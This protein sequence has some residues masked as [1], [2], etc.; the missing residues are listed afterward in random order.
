MFT[1]LSVT[2]GL[3]ALLL[4]GAYALARTDA[5]THRGAFVAAV[6]LLTVGGVVAGT[7][8]LGSDVPR[9]DG[10]AA[11]VAG[12]Q[13]ATAVTD[14]LSPRTDGSLSPAQSRAGEASAT[15]GERATVVA[16]SGSE[17]LTYRTPAGRERTVRLAGVDAPGVDGADPNRFDGVVT[18]EYGRTCLA[19]YGRRALLSVRSGVVG[20]SVTVTPV[21][22]TTGVSAAV[23]TVDGRSVNRRLVERGLARATTDRYADAE[24]AARSADRGVWSCATVRPERPIRDTDG[25]NVRI[26]AVHPN[27]PGSDAAAL[28]DEYVVVENTGR[29]TV[30]LSNWYLA[31]GDD[32]AY[33]FADGALRPGESVVLHVGAGR[34]RDGHVYW[35]AT[36]PV[37][38]NDHESLRLVDGDT[39][40]VVTVTY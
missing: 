9:A 40:R 38:D 32:Q 22:T 30:D 33:F 5:V 26:A 8:P 17:W 18:G 25:P 35:G 15:A 27:P 6:V 14:R 2:V 36:S 12:T 31:D 19:D 11:A 13:T 7:A 21:R 34:D 23:V 20:E 4:G 28:A 29:K 3:T 16:I 24:R 10:D 39:D 1:L 37:L